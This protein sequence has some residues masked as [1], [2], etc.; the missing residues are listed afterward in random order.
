MTG[1]ERLNNICN[2]L[3]VDRI[4]WTTLVDDTT[5]SI[6][7]RQIREMLPFDFYRYIGCDI[8]QFGNYG[9]PR[10]HQIL[11]P[12]RL[13]TPEIETEEYTASNGLVIRKQKTPW[14]TLIA[15]FK[16]KHPVKYPVESVK[17]L[18]ILKNI[19]LN[20]RYEEINAMKESYSLINEEIGE[21]G[22]YVPTV[23]PS[24]IQQLIQY[25]VGLSNFYYLLQDY[26]EEMEE[27]FAVMHRCR[28]QEY[29]IYAEKMPGNIMISVENTSS[30]SI[31]PSIY[32]KYSVPQIRDFV[33]I[34]Y[35]YNK[36]AIIHMCG[37]LKNLLPVIKETGLDGINALTPPPV[38]DTSPEEALDVL[39]EDLI[40]LGFIF[41][42]AIFHKTPVSAEKI[43]QSLEKI[44]TPRIRSSH[45]LLWLPADGLPTSLERFL[46][47]RDW[48]KENGRCKVSL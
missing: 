35:K 29:E 44:F 26:Q 14:G 21:S 10:S 47:V 27:L 4:A 46:I 17:E 19:W 1:R 6:M 12:C 13:I 7:P 25:D 36:K 8:L 5:R 38:G 22:I 11:P 28:L 37:L 23:G 18:R 16:E 39:G 43:A 15:T 32:Q 42:S 41:D 48:M 34:T 9:L 40:I 45:F 30:T 24:P 33:N 3:P 20:S 31:S 2:R